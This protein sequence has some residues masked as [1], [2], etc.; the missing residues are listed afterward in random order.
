[1]RLLF[2][3]V[4]FLC[5]F[6][7]QGQYAAFSIPDSLVDNANAVIRDYKVVFEIRS[8]KKAKLKVEKVVT[9]LN[10]K[11]RENELTIWY[12][13]GTK[14][15][16]IEAELFD[17]LGRPIRTVD[18]NEV[19]DYAAV[20]GGTLYSDRR[21][22]HVEVRHSTYPYTLSY[23][24]ERELEGIDFAVGE[25]W[26]PQGFGISVEKAQFTFIAPKDF[27]VNYKS[28][29]LAVEPERS[30]TGADWSCT[31]NIASLSA[32]PVEAFAPSAKEILPKVVCVPGKVN[33]DGFEGEL[34]DWATFS[35]YFYT[36]WEGQ[37]ALPESVKKEVNTLIEGVTSDEEK[38]TVLYQYLQ[39]NMRYVSVQL[40]IGGWQ[41]FNAEYVANNKYGDCK[42]LT[43]Y[44]WAL[45]GEAGIEAYP[46]LIKSGGVPND[47]DSS[48]IKSYFNHV[49]LYLPEQDNWLEC[50]SSTNPSNYISYGNHDRKVLLIKPEGG[51]LMSTP[52]LGYLEN[53]R[54][55]STEV[56]LDEKGKASLHQEFTMVAR[57]ADRWRYMEV[58]LSDEEKRERARDFLSNVPGHTV[59]EL[60]IASDPDEPVCSVSM[61]GASD[62]FAS[63]A[64]NRLF[65]PLLP[66]NSMESAPSDY[67]DR[68]W[69]VKVDEGF[70][71]RDTI[72]HY[73]PESYSVESIGGEVITHEHESGYY[74]LKI[75]HDAKTIKVVRVLQRKM[76]ALPPES[77]NE[78][79]K[80]W[81][82]VNKLEQ[83]MA[84]LIKKRT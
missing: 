14:V 67:E 71:Y 54:T 15:R 56:H 81:M 82:D 79:R 64:G 2:F 53:I 46:A 29:R 75:E 23:S 78:F 30:E 26:Y 84:V 70:T 47:I 24:Y 34:S 31:W 65:L 62:H 69:P 6:A 44:M 33:I 13:E 35:R 7:T 1:M 39:D 32:L 48:L 8:D 45:L 51:H 55:G 63:K 52:H 12:D 16:K 77:Y 19:K 49:L 18:K 80:F 41:P 27:P 76:T 11:S 42:A 66:V 22:K 83:S 20:S 40:G 73:L 21:I 17:G 37:K 5:A 43:N 25:E 57:D 72:I 28:Y 38:I 74:Q 58:A 60:N 4:A 10:Q 3:A 9:L 61:S 36:L 59:T 68:H 50:T